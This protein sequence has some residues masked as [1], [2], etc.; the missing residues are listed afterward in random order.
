ML[1]GRSQLTALGSC[2]QYE[3][4]NIPAEKKEKKAY[5]LIAT[6]EVFMWLENA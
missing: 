5:V 1:G 6:G 4:Q 2:S 3:S